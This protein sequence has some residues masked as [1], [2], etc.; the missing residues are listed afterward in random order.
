MCFITFQINYHTRL[1]QELYL[2]GSVPELGNLT[3]TD[4]LRL[5]CKGDVWST[6]IEMGMAGEIEYCYL[7]KEQGRTIRREWGRLRRLHVD[8]SA[9]F[10][11]QDYWRERPRHSYLYATAFTD[12]IFFHPTADIVPHTTPNTLM[13]NVHAPFVKKG[14][15]LVLSGDAEQ[16]GN[17]DLKRALPIDYLGKCE[18]QIALDATTLPDMI[19]Y[20]F[21]IV[22][23]DS[24]QPVAWEEGDNRCL[25]TW[26][27]KNDNCVQVEMGLQFRYDRFSFKGT[28]TAIPLFSLRSDSSFGIGDFLDLKKM[29]DWVGLTG[30]QLVQLLPVNDTTATRTWRDSYPYSAISSYALHPVYLGL[31][32]FPLRNRAL[33]DALLEEAGR[34]NLLSEVDYEKVLSLKQR[35]L[36]ELFEQER[37]E[38]LSSASYQ[39]FYEKNRNWLFPYSVYCYL[40]DRYETPRF[41]EWGQFAVY[42]EDKALRLVND[43]PEARR[44]VDFTGFVQYLLDKQLC[45]AREYAYGK[46]IVLK[47]DIPI[48]VNRYSVEAWTAG[49]LFHMDT[50]TGA[51][52]DDFSPS[53]QNWGFPTYNW[54]AMEQDGFAWWKGRLRKMADYFAAYRIDHI[55]GFFRIWEIPAHSVQGL[56]GHFSPALPYAREEL[57]RAGIPFDEERMTKPFIHESYLPEIFGEFTSEVIGKY[58]DLSGWRQ[59]SLKREVDTQRK[60]EH[61]FSGESDAKSLKIR[62]GLYA[63]CN[64]VL[65]VRD[66]MN[67]NLFHPRI[68][69]QH[70]YSYSHLDE[71]VKVALNRLYDDFYYRRHNDFWREQAMRKLPRLISSTSMLV[72]GEDLGMVPDCVHT[73]MEELQI[74]SLEIQ[75]MP[76]VSNLTFA[77]LGS[78]PYLS[79]ATTSTH[80]MSPVRLWWREDRKTTQ[81]F[82]NEVLHR[83]GDAPG[84][85]S[86]ELCRQIIQQH[87]DASAMWVI[88]PWQDWMSI[89]EKLSRGNPA[90]ER[91]NVPANPHHYWRY[92]M[93]ISLDD[94]L[95][96]SELNMAIKTMVNRI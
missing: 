56:L 57:I 77:D 91:I 71:N 50:Q 63:L 76:K 22:D 74:L 37:R 6:T 93:H 21:V 47:G 10:I 34:L 30:Q 33:M 23:G 88:L 45:E 46:G 36:E 80:D 92:R 68:A 5:T 85:S 41:S 49:Y 53:G 64:E 82:F 69:L 28:G 12:S 15:T 19:Q 27:A 59:F 86:P 11:V 78:L 95:K 43:N 89:S 20:K 16:L 87:L 7:L 24:R 32:A 35:Y 96:E 67:H 70:S 17:W 52:P 4:A 38:V 25:C 13:L 42:N 1:G 83:A 40:R 60:I 73:V 26:P 94:L 51:P 44:S 31:A 75:R 3:E 61:L 29:I 48:G 58:L 90:E 66:R 72:C 39:A 55:L 65:F 54:K 81:R 18:W 8:G 9:T 79:V 84:D 62:D 2:S 14:E